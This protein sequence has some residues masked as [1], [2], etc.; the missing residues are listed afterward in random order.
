MEE[1]KKQIKKGWRIF[2]IIFDIVFFGIYFVCCLVFIDPK[3]RLIY[4][5]GLHDT[6]YALKLWC[7]SLSYLAILFLRL[8]SWKHCFKSKR[9]LCFGRVCIFVLSLL[10][11][12]F[13]VSFLPIR[14]PGY[15]PF[16]EGFHQRMKNRLDVERA[17]VWMRNLDKELFED[18]MYVVMSTK[19]LPFELPKEITQLS[20]QKSYYLHLY[21]NEEHLQCLRIEWGGHFRGG[22]WGVV[23]GPREM[24]I[25]P[26]EDVSYDEDGF[27][28]IGEHRLKL[29]D[30]AYVWHEIK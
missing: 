29:E 13:F 22:R 5:D 15:I 9:T 2:W 7:I 28:N 24:Q 18:N 23:V 1:Q 6:L 20:D 3:G 17:R 19:T 11:N 8:Y 21:Q 12:P 27:R 30:G 10:F 16:T 26:T 25:P 4:Y 14:P